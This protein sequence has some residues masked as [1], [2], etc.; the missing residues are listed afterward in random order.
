MQC[1]CWHPVKHETIGLERNDAS[2]VVKYVSGRHM[3]SKRTHTHIEMA[4]N[5]LVFSYSPSKLHENF[6]TIGNRKLENFFLYLF[7]LHSVDCGSERAP[8]YTHTHGFT[9]TRALYVHPHTSTV[10]DCW[11]TSR[12]TYLLRLLL[13]AKFCMLCFS[14]KFPQPNPERSESKNFN[15]PRAAETSTTTIT[16]ALANNKPDE[17]TSANGRDYNCN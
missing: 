12:Y 11:H 2:G 6:C 9:G 16:G 10:R 13:L 3:G 1:G 15:A 5:F 7:W 17:D 14:S 8:S 4:Y